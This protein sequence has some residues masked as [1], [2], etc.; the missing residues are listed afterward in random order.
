[1][2]FF[3][4]RGTCRQR[5]IESIAYGAFI[6]EYNTISFIIT[7]NTWPSISGPWNKRE[8]LQDNFKVKDRIACTAEFM[9]KVQDQSVVRVRVVVRV[10]RQSSVSR[11]CFFLFLFCKRGRIR[12]ETS[13]TNR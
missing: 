1:M 5:D 13:G 6:I 8:H 3:D 12:Q 11:I 9:V 4:Y 7:L 2:R 10:G